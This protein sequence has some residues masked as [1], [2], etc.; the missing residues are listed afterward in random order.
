MRDLKISQIA[1][2]RAKAEGEID[3]NFIYK[4]EQK[5]NQSFVRVKLEPLL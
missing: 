1:R 5:E 4:S 2:I 3:G